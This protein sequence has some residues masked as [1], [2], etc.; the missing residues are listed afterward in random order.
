MGQE[1]LADRLQI[2]QKVF[3]P[4]LQCWNAS[5]TEQALCD[6]LFWSQ[7]LKTGS[8]ENNSKKYWPTRYHDTQKNT[9]ALQ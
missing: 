3:S 1:G 4:K 7:D 2:Q 6:N 9:P 5:I 8:Q